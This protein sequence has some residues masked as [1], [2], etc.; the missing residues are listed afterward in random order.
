MFLKNNYTQRIERK[1]LIECSS[2][3][4]VEIEIIK[5][6]FTPIY[7]ER[8]IN[9]LYYDTKDFRCYKDSSEGIVPRKKYRIRSYNGT[10]PLQL[11]IKNQQLNGR[12]KTSKKIEN[13]YTT[14]FDKYYGLLEQKLF[15]TYQRKYFSN[16][17]LRL[18]VDYDVNFL[19][20]N[21]QKAINK[22]IVILEL[23]PLL[24]Y[25]TESEQAADNIFNV[26]QISF[27]KYEKGVESLFIL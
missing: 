14:I 20:L 23:K 19:T 7:K 12:Y 5:H 21:N 17:Y 15:V 4:S 10:A 24:E 8:F 11:E 9:S 3:K 13:Y 16:N 22:N 1:Y 2:L 18:T 27:S 6:K 25:S 26:P